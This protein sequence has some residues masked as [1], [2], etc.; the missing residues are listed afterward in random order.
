M[1]G[2]V[3]RREVRSFYV[4]DFIPSWPPDTA[5]TQ[6]SRTVGRHQVVDEIV[7]SFTHERE[8]PF[9]LPGV[10]PTGRRVDLA[11]AVVVGFEGAKIHHERIWDQASLLAQLGLLEAGSL[12]VAAAEQSRRLLDLARTYTPSP[13]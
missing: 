5:T 3:G 9:I 2:G 8:T 12:P 10:A 4:E 7:V 1:T 6:V 11:F 13:D